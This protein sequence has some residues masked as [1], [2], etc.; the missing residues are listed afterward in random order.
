MKSLQNSLNP[1][2]FRSLHAAACQ[3]QCSSCNLREIC[4]PV[5]LTR[6]ELE[7]IEHRLVVAQ[8]KVARPPL[9]S[10][11]GGQPTF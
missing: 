8:R 4:L 7:R 1:Q 3:V 6:D 10:V 9:T 2:L 11:A 5:G